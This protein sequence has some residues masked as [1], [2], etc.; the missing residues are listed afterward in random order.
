VNEGLSASSRDGNRGLSAAKSQILLVRGRAGY[1]IF[2]PREI[3]DAAA[4]R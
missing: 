1:A 3:L 2:G 4:R